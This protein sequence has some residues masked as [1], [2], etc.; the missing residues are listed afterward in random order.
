MCTSP[1]RRPLGRPADGGTF[2]TPPG[3][4]SFVCDSP[5]SPRYCTPGCIRVL[6]RWFRR[7]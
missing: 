1:C 4:A 7:R 3:I 5:Q 2:D 6:P